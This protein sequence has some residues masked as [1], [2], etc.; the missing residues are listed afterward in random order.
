MRTLR[1]KLTDNRVTRPIKQATIRALARRALSRRPLNRYFNSLAPEGQEAFHGLHS[2]LFRGG[3]GK[4]SD[5]T[6][7]VHFAGET[8]VLPLRSSHAWLDWDAALSLT[9]HDVEVKQVYEKLV[10]SGDV[11]LFLDV[12][13]NHGTHSLLFLAAGIQS[14]SYEPNPEC[15]D[16]FETV[17]R[18]NGM[19]GRWENV[20]LGEREGEA[21]LSFPEG[22]TWLGS[23]GPS[24]ED[25]LKSC[26]VNVVTLDSYLPAV[27]S[28]KKILLK[29]DTE[30]HE[31]KV[32]AGA[33]RLISELRPT[34]IFEAIN[35]NPRHVSDVLSAYG[36][37][38]SPLKSGGCINYIAVG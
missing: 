8:I 31:P 16:Y 12:G 9:G 19:H 15:R 10:K 32:L 36:Y 23:I 34:I 14:V 13:A 7:E 17:C 21:I 30:G 35:G 37:R 6:W 18:M 27:R 28:A 38:T 4:F 3:S 25:G 20:A 29:I 2:G 1:S 33:S 26:P 5:G 24:S 22:R 11:D